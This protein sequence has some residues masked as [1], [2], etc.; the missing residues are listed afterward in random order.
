MM[1]EYKYN[2]ENSQPTHARSGVHSN[3]ISKLSDASEKYN[4]PFADTILVFSDAGF[5]LCAQ[6]GSG[7]QL[8]KSASH[9]FYSPFHYVSRKQRLQ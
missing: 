3:K 4:N 8:F 6:P 1:A 7:D 2:D 9:F 5:F